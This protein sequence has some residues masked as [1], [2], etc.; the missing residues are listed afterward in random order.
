MEEV[1]LPMPISPSVMNVPITLTKSSG[2]LV[3]PA[4]NVA[5]HISLDIFN[6][7][8]VVVQPRAMAERQN[9][10]TKCCY[11]RET[12]RE[13]VHIRVYQLPE[14]IF[15]TAGTKYLSQT[16]ASAKNK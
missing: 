7:E 9:E 3:A 15:S 1:Q 16:T 13:D 6:A 4:I 10:K 12:G 2:L 5:P 14:H 8:I 11:L